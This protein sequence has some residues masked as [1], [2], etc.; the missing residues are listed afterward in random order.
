[1]DWTD[2][3]ARDATLAAVA[4]LARREG[5]SV[6]KLE[7]DSLTPRPMAAAP[8]GLVPSKQTIQPPSTIMLD[9]SDDEDA[10]LQRMKSKWRYNVRLAARKGV[11]VHAMARNDPARIRRHDADDRQP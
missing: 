4:E 2:R 5:A 6:L 3:A 10:I 7:P 11:T 9:I 1:M 8:A